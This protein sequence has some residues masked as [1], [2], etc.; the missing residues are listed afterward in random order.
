VG[1]IKD[2]LKERT[3]WDGLVLIAAGVAMIVVPVGLV[4]VGCIAYG[5]WTVWKAE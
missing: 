1:W 4:G 3:T 5:A 2:R